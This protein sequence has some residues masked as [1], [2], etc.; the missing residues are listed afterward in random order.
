M[1]VIIILTV[2]SLSV[3]GQSTPADKISL[4]LGVLHLSTDTSNLTFY[5]RKGGV[6]VVHNSSLYKDDWRAFYKEFGTFIVSTPDYT[7]SIFRTDLYFSVNKKG[8][9]EEVSLSNV[10]NRVERQIKN[11]IKSLNGWTGHSN[12]D[13]VSNR[14]FYLQ[15]TNEEVIFSVVEESARPAGG[16]NAFYEH[17]LI[18]LQYPQEARR[19]G[20]EGRVFVEFVIEKNGELSNVRVIKGI[21]FGC[22]EE[23][24]RVVLSSPGWIPGYQRGKPVRQRYVIPMIFKLAPVN[25]K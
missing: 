25:N 20:I 8:E 2:F 12:S 7:D 1:L 13:S 15:I 5:D 10:S 6:G 24:V 21:G 4:D 19:H 18:N 23:A 11:A 22:D 3:N 14:N 17:V 9:I 16:M